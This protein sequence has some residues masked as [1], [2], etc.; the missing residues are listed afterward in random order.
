M[1][2]SLRRANWNNLVMN[3]C[4]I[5]SM[6]RKEKIMSKFLRGWSLINVFGRLSMSLEYL[7]RIICML[8]FS[9]NY[10]DCLF[11]KPM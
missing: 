4:R 2:R 1:F 11:S 9:V 5:S 6:L 10:L 8:F 7:H 3:N